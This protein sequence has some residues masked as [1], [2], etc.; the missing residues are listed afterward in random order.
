MGMEVVYIPS[1]A[2]V[3]V[4]TGLSH[5]GLIETQICNRNPVP[6]SGE[7]AAKGGGCFG[8]VASAP[9]LSGARGWLQWAWRLC[10]YRLRRLPKFQPA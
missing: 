2:T 5:Q 4:S 7:P 1:E 3:K 8:K 10:I 6:L 9:G